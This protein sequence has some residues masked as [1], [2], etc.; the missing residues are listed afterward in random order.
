MKTLRLITIL[1]GVLSV[2]A[3]SS[4]RKDQT[5][6]GL[7]IDMSIEVTDISAINAMLKIS[8]EGDEPALI[9]M[10]SAVPKAEVIEA[11]GSLDNSEAVKSYISG[12]GEAI[13][14]PYSAVLKDL[15]PETAYFIGVAAYDSEMNVYGYATTTFT[16]LDLSSITDDA[17]GDPSDAGSLTENELE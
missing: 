5:Q 8:G 4:C 15:N 12:H 17:L 2:V 9:R 14:L 1:A 10:V 7:S 6:P 11:V 13:S 16:T 3:L